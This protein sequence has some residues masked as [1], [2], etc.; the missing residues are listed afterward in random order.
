LGAECLPVLLW[1]LDRVGVA[2]VFFNL[3]RDPCG[4]LTVGQVGF[5][6]PLKWST[7]SGEVG[8]RRS[9]AT[10]VTVM[11]SEEPH[12]WA[13]NVLRLQIPLRGRLPVPKVR[14]VRSHLQGLLSSLNV[15][16]CEHWRSTLNHN[17]LQT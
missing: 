9:E 1:F 7:D 10:L 5:R 3:T 14:G 4:A 16:R 8:Q 13:R 2:V 6:I 17:P 12:L 11:I 15:P